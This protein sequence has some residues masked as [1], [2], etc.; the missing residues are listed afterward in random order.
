MSEVHVV[1][2]GECLSSIARD[3][4]FQD[5]K[6]LYEH[7]AN[8][9]LKKRRPN[10]NALLPGDLIAIPEKKFL[11][12]NR[13]TGSWHE[14]TVQAE[15]SRLKLRLLDVDGTPLANQ[16]YQLKI[17]GEERAGTTDGDGLLDEPVRPNASA[18]TVTATVT[19]DD[20]P[21]DFVWDLEIGALDPVSQMTGVQA[22]L[23]NL[24]FYHGEL[25]GN[26]GPMTRQAVAAF[27]ESRGLEPTGE[28]DD[29]TLKEIEKQHDGRA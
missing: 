23:Q 27:Q 21:H 26:F 17:D 22:R 5:W 2:Q 19:R 28:A 11:E 3:H 25:D 9:E 4:G 18:A 1:R 10:P 14:F 20:E 6:V 12:C 15:E 16:A 8:A 24:Q 7:P 13:P 29:A